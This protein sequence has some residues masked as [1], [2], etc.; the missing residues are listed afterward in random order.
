MPSVVGIIDQIEHLPL[1]VL[2]AYLDHAGPYA[3]GN[4]V[5]D[6]WLDGVVL[7][8]VNITMGVIV[9]I[10]GA[11]APFLGRTLGFDDGGTIDLTEFELRITQLAA[12]HQTLLGTWIASQV[13]D[14]FYAPQ[15]FRW[16]ESNPGRIG[17]YVS[18][19]WSIDLY[20][21]LPV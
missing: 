7:R 4:H 18:P 8:P 14:I 11:I 13:A 12:L 2:D 1:G 21:L 5:L 10:N 9:Q 6:T 20:Y 15:L 3:A 16:V 19:S 17:L